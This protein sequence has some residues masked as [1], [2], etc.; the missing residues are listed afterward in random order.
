MAWMAAMSCDAADRTSTSSVRIIRLLAIQD[1]LERA[2]VRA[3]VFRRALAHQAAG[4]A[5]HVRPYRLQSGEAAPRLAA[6]AVVAELE[7]QAPLGVDGR[8]TRPGPFLGG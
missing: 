5:H 6:V 4:V 7:G 1:A 3:G 2:E 8:G